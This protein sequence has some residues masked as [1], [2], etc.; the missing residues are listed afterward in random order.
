MANSL[1]I[2]TVRSNLSDRVLPGMELAS[3]DTETFPD[4]QPPVSTAER[5][6]P[7]KEISSVPSSAPEKKPE[8]PAEPEKPATPEPKP[9]VKPNPEKQ[10][11][12]E[13]SS[14]IKDKIALF[15]NR[16]STTE[17]NKPSAR[18]DELEAITQLRKENSFVQ[19]M[20]Q[21]F[22]GTPDKH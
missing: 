2:T 19:N 6:P 20:V 3:T 7:A 21:K 5:K 14:S 17:T 18:E 4:A 13:G 15:G 22:N 10:Q 9:P 8:V 1:W 16:N 12:A 11:A